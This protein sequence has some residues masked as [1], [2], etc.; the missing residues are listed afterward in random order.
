MQIQWRQG[1]GHFKD[2]VGRLISDRPSESMAAI[3]SFWSSPH[4][5][6]VDE[7]SRWS[8]ISTI[9]CGGHFMV[10]C[11][12]TYSWIVWQLEVGSPIITFAVEVQLRIRDQF[13]IPQ[14]KLHGWMYL[15]FFVK[16]KN[17]LVWPVSVFCLKKVLC[18]F[19]LSE[20]RKLSSI[21]ETS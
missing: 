6:L 13:W 8:T 1:G 2:I 20:L 12:V 3:M 15:I 9:K 10:R 5:S 18:S 16:P 21:T 14:P 11:I 4:L 17:G 19:F 7:N